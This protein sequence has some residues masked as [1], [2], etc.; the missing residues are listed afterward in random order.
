MN[1]EKIYGDLPI[2]ETERLI[3]RKVTLEDIQDMYLYGSDEEVSKYV[4]WNTL[5]TISDTKGFVE[6]V[7]NKYENKQVS[8]WGIE[9][10]ENGK[11]IATIDFVWWQPNNKTA[12][13]GYVISKDYW[14]KGLTSEVAKEIIKFGFEKMDLVRIQA[15]CDVENIGSARVME[16]AGMSFEGIIRKGIFVKGMHRDLKMYSILKEEFNYSNETRT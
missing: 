8:P 6:F 10:K 2:L 4:T 12:E 3:L 14:R 13:I 15:R 7:L 5:E 11:F 1:V 9:C 16:K